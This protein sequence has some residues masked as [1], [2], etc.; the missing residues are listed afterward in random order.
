MIGRELWSCVRKEGTLLRRDPH[1]LLLLFAMPTV[2]ILIMS[3]ALQDQFAD[4]SGASVLFVVDADRTDAA[5]RLVDGFGHNPSLRVVALDAGQTEES[6]RERLR[7]EGR[8]FA[9]WIESGFGSAVEGGGSAPGEWLRVTVAPESDRQREALLQG[10]LRE[11]LGRLQVEVFSARVGEELDL[12]LGALTEGLRFDYMYGAGGEARAPSSV[13]QNV[14]AWLVFAVF[15]VAIP[16]SNTMIRE[17]QLGMDRRLRTTPV[18]QATIL[19][20]KLLP[21]FVVNQAQ[22]VG[23]LLVGVF[24]VPALGG[25]ALE[26]TGVPL[27]SLAL[28]AAAVSVAALGYALLI[29]VACSTTEQATMLGGAGNIIL[30]A[31][32]GIMV[33]KFIMPPLLQSVTQVSPMAWGLDGLLGA[34]LHAGT[35]RDVA[36]QAAALGVFGGVAIIL[37]WWLQCRR[38]R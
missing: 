17:R 35:L 38:A 1:A 2:F 27:G 5:S 24:L 26:L 4:D 32:G 21:Y 37:A 28:M 31:I 33:P 29:A 36:P 15:F 8:A 9:L 13:Q 6:V 22:V 18:S 20:G 30:A 19:A 34:L 3:L 25:D 11:S 12:D 16:L 7:A 23:M 14:P 10:A